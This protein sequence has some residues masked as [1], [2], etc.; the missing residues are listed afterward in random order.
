MWYHAKVYMSHL[1]I[2]L[3]IQQLRLFTFSGIHYWI[4]NWWNYLYNITSEK[5]TLN[6]TLLFPLSLNPLIISGFF[7][8]R[9]FLRPS[10]R[11]YHLRWS[12]TLTENSHEQRLCTI[13]KNA[14]RELIYL[15]HFSNK[16]ELFLYTLVQKQEPHE[17]ETMTNMLKLKP[18]HL[19]LLISNY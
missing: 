3:K 2:T 8:S 12:G 16:I 5:E 10:K 13:W 14:Q 18:Q 17:H 9:I 15:T 4:S 1:D 19:Q 6:T 11:G 7:V